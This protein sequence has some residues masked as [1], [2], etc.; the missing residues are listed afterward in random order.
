MDDYKSGEV[1]SMCV[2]NDYNDTVDETVQFLANGL[3]TPQSINTIS[4]ELTKE[5]SSCNMGRPS[6]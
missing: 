4:N 2:P 1:F 3:L 6:T 5:M